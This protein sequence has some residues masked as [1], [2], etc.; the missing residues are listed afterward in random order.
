MLQD[1][2]KSRV[3]KYEKQKGFLTNQSVEAKVKYS[4]NNLKQIES[5][6][7]YFRILNVKLLKYKV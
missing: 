6:Y 5:F 1:T 3:M 7:F 2:N 4:S